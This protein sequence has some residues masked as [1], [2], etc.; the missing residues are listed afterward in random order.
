MGGHPVVHFE[1]NAKDPTVLSGFYSKLFGWHVESMP[2]MGYEMVDPHAGKGIGGGFNK[3]DDAPQ[4]TVFYVAT[5]DLKATI[6]K[7]E[8]LGAKVVVP[9]TE[10]PNVVTFAQIADP[11]GTILGLVL[12][13]GSQENPGPSAGSNPEVGWFEIMSP[14]A[15]S[16]WSF[17][18]ELFGWEIKGN[19]GP[20][21]YG[22]VD[23]KAEG[24]V[25]GGIGAAPDGTKAVNMYASV[26][27]V[28]RFLD[29]ATELGG[30][31][32]F[33]PMD[34]NE[35]LTV[36]MFADPAGSSFGLFASKH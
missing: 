14:D 4:H 21:I 28:Q 10:I 2:E 32:L 8:T 25:N 15:K 35:H 31:A 23:T 19:D 26:D 1:I 17:Y 30:K 13:D 16:L 34:V 6:A 7:A 36:G 20:M 24:G 11:S 9:I 5:D 3:S 27:D 18:S 33:G 22:E 12:D 29:K